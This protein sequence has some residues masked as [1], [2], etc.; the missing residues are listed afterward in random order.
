MDLRGIANAV[1]DTVNP[2]ISVT[3]MA[4]SGY[5]IG[6]GLKQIPLYADPDTGF[7]QI[8]ALTQADIRH[9][10]GLNIQGEFAAIILRGPL[11]G[12]I[13]ANSQGGDLVIVAGPAPAQFQGTW[14]VNS[15]LEAWPLW[16][17]ALLVRQNAQWSQGSGTPYTGWANN[18]IPVMSGENFT[19][20]YPPNPTQS[21]QWFVQSLG[22]GWIL[23]DQGVDY[24]LLGS[25]ITVINGE[26]YCAYYTR[27]WYRY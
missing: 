10:D 20:A 6:A 2:N 22:F 12:V 8:Q 1:S 27:A 18:E 3:V 11:A 16:I 26:H 7:A 13:R 19:L 4:S 25:T 17:R 23:L 15:V 24:T 5:T 14:L 21:L 9:L